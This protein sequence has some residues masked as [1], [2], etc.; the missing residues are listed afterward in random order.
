MTKGQKDVKRRVAKKKT[1]KER[2]VENI[3]AQKQI[4]V[5][6]RI[7]RKKKAKTREKE[8]SRVKQDADK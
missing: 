6:K 2:V 5:G 3:H 7:R 8:K 4:D 1:E